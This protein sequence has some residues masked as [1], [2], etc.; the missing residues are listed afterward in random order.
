MSPKGRPETR[1]T[2][3]RIAEGL[4]RQVLAPRRGA[5]HFGLVSGGSGRDDLHRPAT[6]GRSLRD[7]ELCP[8]RAGP[9]A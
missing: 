2:L 5:F 6:F 8:S 3:I 4:G 9:P 7:L 1:R